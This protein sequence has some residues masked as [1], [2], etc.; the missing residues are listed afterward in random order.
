MKSIQEQLAHEHKVLKGETQ[1]KPVFILF[2]F[3]F[4]GK[5]FD[6]IIFF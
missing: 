4:Y 1:R 2:L 6:L 3:D 5:N